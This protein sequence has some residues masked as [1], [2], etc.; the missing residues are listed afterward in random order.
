MVKKKSVQ[1]KTKTKKPEYGEKQRLEDQLVVS[2]YLTLQQQHRACVAEMQNA[3]SAMQQ[4]GPTA[5][6]A[7]Q[8]LSANP[9]E[10]KDD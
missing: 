8:R 10:V 9:E 7:E 2:R 6:A 4:L 3:A 5:Q 1:T